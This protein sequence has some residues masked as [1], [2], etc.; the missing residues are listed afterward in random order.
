MEGQREGRT[1]SKGP[2]GGLKQAA[3]HSLCT[4]GIHGLKWSEDIHTGQQNLFNGLQ[5]RIHVKYFCRIFRNQN[6][7]PSFICICVNYAVITNSWQLD[8][9]SSTPMKCS[10]LESPRVACSAPILSILNVKNKGL[11]KMVLVVVVLGDLFGKRV[12]P[13]AVLVFFK[14]VQLEYRNV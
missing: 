10:V 13:A 11:M 9:W 7:T 3:G 6:N 2:Q 4:W 1:D 12:S 5:D 8:W 14:K